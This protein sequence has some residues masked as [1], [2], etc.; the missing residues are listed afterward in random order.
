MRT[1][2]EPSRDARRDQSR[3]GRTNRENSQRAEP[4]RQ[5]RPVEGRDDR[6]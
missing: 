1:V 2:G 4:R 6:T 5:E 3:A